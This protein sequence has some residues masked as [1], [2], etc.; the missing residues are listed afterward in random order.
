MECEVVVFLQQHLIYLWNKCYQKIYISFYLPHIKASSLP[1]AEMWEGLVDPKL[2]TDAKHHFNLH[3]AY[4]D[5]EHGPFLAWGKRTAFMWLIRL[6]SRHD[7]QVFVTILLW[8]LLAHRTV[9][10]SHFNLLEALPRVRIC[11]A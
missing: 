6:E 5:K 1:L 2:S 9:L 11:W 3:N 8:L 7:K 4:A 10:L